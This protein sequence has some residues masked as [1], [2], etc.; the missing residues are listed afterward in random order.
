MEVPARLRR[1]LILGRSA[2]VDLAPHADRALA[3]GAQ[4]VLVTV[5]YPV[6][7]PHTRAV[8]DALRLADERGLF[9]EAALALSPDEAR[10]FVRT[11]DR[12][13]IVAE[14]REQRKIE[15]AVNGLAAWSEPGF[16]SGNGSRP[17]EA[18]NEPVRSPARVS[19][20]RSADGVPG[21]DRPDSSG[22]EVGPMPDVEGTESVEALAGR[23]VPAPGRETV[24]TKDD[25]LAR[26]QGHLR[27]YLGAA[28]GVGKTYSMLGEGQRRRAR[29]SDVLVAGV[30]TYGRPKTEEMLRGLEVW[31][32]RETPYRG[33]MFPELDAAGLLERRPEVALIDELAHTNVPGSPRAKRWEDVL[34]LLVAGITVI[35]TLN[36]QHLASVNDVVAA[37]TGIRQL[38]TVP[39]WILDL[40]DDVELVDMSPRALQRRMIHG[41][42]YPDPRKAELALRRFFTIENLTALR[43]LALMRVANQVDDELL[44]RWRRTAIAE[45]RERVLVLVSRPEVSEELVRRGG[46][47]AQ[48]TQGD[49]LVAHLTTG[50]KPPDPVWIGSTRRLVADLG[51][52]FEVLQA[53]DPV[54]RVLAFATQQH[55]TQILVGESRRS[56]WQELIRGSFVNRLIRQAQNVD[57]HVIA[58]RD[59]SRSG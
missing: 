55:V 53:D 32:P 4:L 6:P 57:I 46:R 48:R 58:R 10:D 22:E 31:P 52:E 42:I 39:D 47:I 17:P 13:T 14:G 41:N 45:T 3:E 21:P 20:D 35:S 56:R 34:D 38:E 8:T 33:T 49:L 29:G 40:A 27:I 44:A 59:R 12:V 37:V 25:A 19:G 30:Q 5:G 50:E 43:E 26:K 28:P 9:V 36:V 2:S 15:R 23:E 51:G 1:V 24:W 7:G 18:S 11:G 16:P 54:E